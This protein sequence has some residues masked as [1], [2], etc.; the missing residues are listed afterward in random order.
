MSLIN[1]YVRAGACTQG[2]FINA[3][4]VQCVLDGTSCPTGS[5]FWSSQQLAQALVDPQNAGFDIASADCLNAD[6]TNALLA[7]TCPDTSAFTQAG[8]CL[9]NGN[10]YQCVTSPEGCADDA[11][12]VPSATVLANANIMCQ[13]CGLDNDDFTALTTPVDTAGG[14]S[15]GAGGDVNGADVDGLD[16][17]D[18]YGDDY[19][20]DDYY[21]DYDGDGLD[22]DVGLNATTPAAGL[23]ATIPADGLGVDPTTLGADGDGFPGF[24]GGMEAT[25]PATPGFGGMDV[26]TPAAAPG[27]FGADATPSATGSGDSTDSSDGST[28]DKYKNEYENLGENQKVEAGVVAGIVIGI[29]VGCC[30]LLYLQR[31]C[32]KYCGNDPNGIDKTHGRHLVGDE[33]GH[34]TSDDEDDFEDRML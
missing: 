13:I 11:T 12:F 21:D 5:T 7:D 19:Y 1:Q 16:G 27:G 2:Q 9:V 24:G 10:I 8:A 3:P 31:L 4:F 33:M 6:G 34:M 17:D 26:T 14:P 28:Y 30:L 20:G 18:Y 22:G 15:L 25:T 32:R 23:D 29:L